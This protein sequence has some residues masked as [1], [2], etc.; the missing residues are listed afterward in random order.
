MGF[1]AVA[2]GQVGAGVDGVGVVE[3]VAEFG[4]GGGVPWRGQRVEPDIQGVG[5]GVGDDVAGAGQGG[6]D[7]GVGLVAGAG[8]A[9]VGD[10]RTRQRLGGVERR[11][12]DGV[13]G[14]FGFGVED[15]LAGVDLE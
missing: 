14:Q 15:L 10:D 12:A 11:D 5:V 1:D 13:V 7:Q 6:V 3:D 9:G 4:D 8:V 2:Q